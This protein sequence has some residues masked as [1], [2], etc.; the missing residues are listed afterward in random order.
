MEGSE[1]KRS[2]EQAIVGNPTQEILPEV[3]DLTDSNFEEEGASDVTE[4]NYN[5]PPP[6]YSQKE[7]T[8]QPRD[9]Y[10]SILNYGYRLYSGT[11][12][13][14][15]SKTCMPPPPPIHLRNLNDYRHHRRELIG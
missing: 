9:R 7:S 11:S 6:P 8:P 14:L 5:L 1:D 4:R 15:S 10:T 12:L 2:E 3:I 13:L